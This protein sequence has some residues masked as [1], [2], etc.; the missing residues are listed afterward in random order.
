MH[1]KPAFKFSIQSNGELRKNL[2]ETWLN[3]TVTV[4]T[5]LWSKQSW[6]NYVWDSPDQNLIE[7]GR[8]KNDQ[9]WPNLVNLALTIIRPNLTGSSLDEIWQ[10]QPRLKFGRILSSQTL[11]N[12]DKVGV[13]SHGRNSIEF[14]WVD[15]DRNYV[16]FPKFDR[17]WRILL[18]WLRSKFSRGRLRLNSAKSASTKILSNSAKSILIKIQPT[19]VESGR[20]LRHVGMD[21][22]SRQVNLGRR[23]RQFDLD[24]GSR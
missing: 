6:T 22:R 8:I 14:D 10:S 9:I 11:S 13:V 21:W 23:M 7:L 2:V 1:C 5:K 4:P 15:P 16:E 17:I 12:L 3:S 20:R 18:G 24:Q 19:L